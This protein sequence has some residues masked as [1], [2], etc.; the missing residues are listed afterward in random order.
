MM[1]QALTAVHSQS[2]DAGLNARFEREVVP[3]RELLYRHAFRMSHNHA[4]TEDLVQE[5]MMRAYAHFDS[6]R[7]EPI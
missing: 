3:L 5:T 2:V 6:F 4:K 7:S 1:K